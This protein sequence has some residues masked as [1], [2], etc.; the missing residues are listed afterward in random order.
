MRKISTLLFATVL[1][2]LFQNANAQNTS[3]YWS[4]AGN[5]NA[6]ATSKLGTT[7]AT[8]L[9]IYT[10]NVQRITVL[11]NNG[12]VGIG[13]TAPTE[14]LHVN[15][16]AGTNA[17]RA[18]I[19]G[20]TKLLVHS[21]G[22]VAVGANVTPPANGL[23]VSGNVGIGTTSPAAKLHVVG[24]GRFTDL[25][26]ITNGGLNVTNTG[27]T[28]ISG[29]GSSTGVYGHTDGYEDSDVGVSG[30]AYGYGVSGSGGNYGVYGN[31][32]TGV[33]GT[34]DNYGVYG[35]ANYCGLYGSG[36]TYGVYA[37]GSSYGLYG[38]SSDG[39]GVGV[40]GYSLNNDGGFFDSNNGNGL[41]AR[42]TN[43][44]YAG[45]FYG[46]VYASGGYIT[47]DK[48]LKGN[49]Q[50]FSDA[51]SIINKLKPRNYD[52]KT[53]EKYAFLKLPGGTHYGL[54]AQDVEEVLPNLVSTANHEVLK[55]SKQAET[56][57]PAV[58]ESTV[59]PPTQQT[60]EK[61]KA[62]TVSIKAVNYI[63]LIPI[64][65]K[66]MQEQE[67]HIEKQDALIEK[68]QQ[69]IEELKNLLSK[70]IGAPA[71]T[72]MGGLSQN[73]PNPATRTARISYSTPDGAVRAQLIVTDNQ[74]RT[75]KTVTLS[76]NG[77]VNL[78]V[79][80]FSSGIYN[81]TLLVDGKITDTK[82]MEVV[83]K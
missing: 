67:Q 12:Y 77:Y 49:V 64:M 68:Q 63:E 28:A 14:L 7:D 80:G 30:S 76:N 27:S 6:S 11:Y 66:G 83:R 4:L 39:N 5:N 22:G 13:T 38:T 52:F 46:A 60:V 73:T 53:D 71:I 36:A 10:N 42:T 69:Q 23:Y 72:S 78:D 41:V 24:T 9:R 15:S 62:E 82:K 59:T 31:G 57:K 55:A 26:T 70:L 44:S 20:N 79:S 74:G 35:T 65:I 56:V 48:R 81:Y 40:K 51:M 43:G 3:P 8:S 54:L 17:F 21:N 61:Q 16:A 29:Y 19:N 75:L 58:N 34:G 18:Q 37:T 47:S 33:K 45:A 1:V 50:E 25:V 32:L 2:A